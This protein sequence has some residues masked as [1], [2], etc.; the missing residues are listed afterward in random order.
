MVELGKY[1][2]ELGYDSLFV[3]ML[4]YYKFSFFEIKYYYDII[5]VEMGNNMIV[6]FILFLIGVNMGIE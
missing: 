2:I 5:I 4:F 1:V 6:Y 3:V